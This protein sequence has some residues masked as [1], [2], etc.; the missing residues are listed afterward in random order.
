[1]GLVNNHLKTSG[2]TLD[3]EASLG[4]TFSKGCK[5]HGSILKSGV[6]ILEGVESIEEATELQECLSIFRMC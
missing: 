4:T 1:L 2:F 5:V 6:V 3:V